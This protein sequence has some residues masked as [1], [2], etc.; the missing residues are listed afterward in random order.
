MLS[1]FNIEWPKGLHLQKGIISDLPFPLEVI[2][3]I[4]VTVC[5]SDPNLVAILRNQN[6]A[7]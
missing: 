3:K 2:D 6:A 1:I 7:I 5:E 4:R